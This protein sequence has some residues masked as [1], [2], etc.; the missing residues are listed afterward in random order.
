LEPQLQT[1]FG[2]A[3][4]SGYWR[5]GGKAVIDEFTNLRWIIV[6]RRQHYPF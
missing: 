3:K 2:G 4:A 5:P 1:P 6:A